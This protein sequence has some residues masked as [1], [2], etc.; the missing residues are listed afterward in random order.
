M[1]T[2]HI[3]EEPYSLV[4]FQ[5]AWTAHRQGRRFVLTTFQNI[6]KR[7]PIPFRWTQDW[8][9]ARARGALVGS[10]DAEGVIRAHGFAGPAAPVALGVDPA[11]YRPQRDQ[12][13]RDDLGLDG[14]VVG[15]VGRL[16]PVKGLPVLFRALTREPRARALIVGSGPEEAALKALVA[17]LNLGPRVTW[18]PAVAHAD[19]P[20]YLGVLD[21]LVA[22][23]VSRPGIREQ[24]GRVLV[25]AMACGVPVIGSSSGEIPRVLGD[26]GLV[27]PEGDDRALAACLAELIG[28]PARRTALT[29]AGAARVAAHYTWDAIA[30]GIA[31]FYREVAG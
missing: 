31:G 22:P 20:R 17:A 6:D 2:R 18:V 27:F 16:D 12:A 30:R 3:E 11:V 13:L 4:T 5:L 21:A 10:P 8:V 9:L 14:F 19:V 29:S 1:K 15:A 24:F 25:E 23:S 26:A 28:S 7:R